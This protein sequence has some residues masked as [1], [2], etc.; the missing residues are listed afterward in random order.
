MSIT[1]NNPS[2]WND[3]KT[4]LRSIFSTIVAMA[5]TS[6]KIVN[7]AENEVDNLN[8]IQ[9]IRLDMTKAERVQQRTDIEAEL[10]TAT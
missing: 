2:I 8:E 6:E 9:M 5:R 10:A 3:I 4:T 1:T 7:L